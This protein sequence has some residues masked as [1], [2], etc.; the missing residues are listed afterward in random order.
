MAFPVSSGRDGPFAGH[1]LLPPNRMA[2]AE[3]G[4]LLKEAG[5]PLWACETGQ[6]A[7]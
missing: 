7:V 5:A 4:A 3:P 2:G 6:N 1:R